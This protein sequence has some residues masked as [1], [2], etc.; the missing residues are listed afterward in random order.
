MVR[1]KRDAQRNNKKTPPKMTREFLCVFSTILAK[2]V[3]AA[4]SA[5][6]SVDASRAFSVAV[7]DTH[8]TLTE[9]ADETLAMHLIE[10]HVASDSGALSLQRFSVAIV[11]D[12]A[13]DAMGVAVVLDIQCYIKPISEILSCLPQMVKTAVAADQGSLLIETAD[14]CWFCLESYTSASDEDNTVVTAVFSDYFCCGHP[15]CMDCVAGAASLKRCG[16]C[17]REKPND[18][19]LRNDIFAET[20]ALIGMSRN[21][22]LP[23]HDPVVISEV[24]ALVR[25]LYV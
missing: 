23:Q 11:V 4:L 7:C 15:L 18:A 9:W 3:G 13:T 24:E 25:N 19:Y 8:S 20:T 6:P 10:R 1:P 2:R 21:N 22:Y 16:I 17:R 12:P 5:Y 14:T